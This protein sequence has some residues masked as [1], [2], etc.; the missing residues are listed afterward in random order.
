MFVPAQPDQQGWQEATPDTAE[1]KP[2]SVKY[3]G[4]YDKLTASQQRIKNQ[5][6]EIPNQEPPTVLEPTE[7][8]EQAI[9]VNKFGMP[10]WLS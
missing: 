4:Q 6:V 2:M 8:T 7:A 1:N 10:L 9:I 5:F 3:L